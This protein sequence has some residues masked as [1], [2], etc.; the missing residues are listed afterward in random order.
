[1]GRK[2]AE[3]LKVKV[4]R[5]NNE[6][7][8]SDNLQ[9]PLDFSKCLAPPSHNQS[10][11]SG[12]RNLLIPASG[13]YPV[14]SKNERFLLYQRWIGSREAIELFDKKT[15]LYKRLSP[16]DEKIE[17]RHAIFWPSKENGWRILFGRK[18][19]GVEKLFTRNSENNKAELIFNRMDLSSSIPAFGKDQTIYFSGSNID[20]EGE[21]LGAPDLFRYNHKTKATENL[22]KSKWEEWRPSPD[23]SGKY[24]YH[25]ANPKGQ[26]D[27]YRIDVA[28]GIKNLFYGSEVDEWDPDISKDGK[29]VVFASRQNGNWDIFMASTDDSRKLFQLTSGITDDWD[30]KF[31]PLSNAIIFAS[32]KNDKP[33]FMYYLCPFGETN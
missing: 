29:W 3:D 21:F 28:T 4:L 12:N 20:S 14:L 10:F 19:N 32:S 33:P 6:T 24:I 18:K 16:D 9:R 22:T 15:N 17:E 8:S 13:R 23:L 27:I 2:I 5:L 25:I 31:T 26:F 7:K 11:S 1:M 30:P